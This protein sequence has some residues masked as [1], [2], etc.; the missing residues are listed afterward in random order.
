MARDFELERQQSPRIRCRRFKRLGDDEGRIAVDVSLKIDAC[1]CTFDR[2]SLGV[3]K[4]DRPPRR[5]DGAPSLLEKA[6][7]HLGRIGNLEQI[8]EERGGLPDYRVLVGEQQGPHFGLQAC[9][10]VRRKA[11]VQR[12]FSKDL[13]GSLAYGRVAI[14]QGGEPSVDRLALDQ[15][16]AVRG[17]RLRFGLV[18]HSI[19]H[20]PKRRIEAVEN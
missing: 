13:D 6:I 17:I 12:T 15:R 5:V 3:D 11:W 7:D 1:Q 8:G 10:L 20:S 19:L 4:S 16:G 18:L 2:S 14:L 9:L